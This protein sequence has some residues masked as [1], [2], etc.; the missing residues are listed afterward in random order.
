L[1]AEILSL[2]TRHGKQRLVVSADRVV[3]DFAHGARRLEEASPLTIVG[4]RWSL[5]AGRW[6]LVAG[7]WSLVVRASS[8]PPESRHLHA[9]D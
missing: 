5:V 4:R 1:D 6:S 7:R 2:I 3:F 8:Y 9:N